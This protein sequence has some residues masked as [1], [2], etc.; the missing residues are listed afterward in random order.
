MVSSPSSAH[1]DLLNKRQYNNL[2][3]SV[4]KLYLGTIVA[5]L[6][7]PGILVGYCTSYSNQVE[8]VLDE[9]FNFD[10]DDKQL[11]AASWIGASITLGMT[12]GAVSGGR[13][14]KIGRRRTLFLTICLGIIG[15]SIT[16]IEDF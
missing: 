1:Q 12:L 14:I 9:K 11:Q 4:N 15:L 3:V 2:D 13:I 5:I 8:F 7:I 10:T 16:L 6:N